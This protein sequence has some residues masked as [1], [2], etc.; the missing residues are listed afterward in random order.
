MSNY[1]VKGQRAL[2]T[3]LGSFTRMK[4]HGMGIDRLNHVHPGQYYYYYYE[5]LQK[6]NFAYFN[7]S[8]SKSVFGHYY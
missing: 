1:N 2:V 8:I 6:L 4:L 3:V 5:Y 7:F